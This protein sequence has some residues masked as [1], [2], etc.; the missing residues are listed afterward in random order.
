MS[1][2][3]LQNILK[4]YRS[5]A[6]STRGLGTKFERLI[7]NFLQNYPL[8]KNG[9]KHVWLW[10]EFPYRADFGGSDLG[11][12]IV[13][14]TYTGD[15]WAI[16]CKCYDEQ[17]FIDKPAVDSFL[18]TTSRTF[19]DSAN[20][21]CKFSFRLWIDTTI[22]G[23]NKNATESTANQDIQ[24]GRMGLDELFAADVDWDKLEAGLHG[25]AVLTNKKTVR[26]HQKNA[27]ENAHEYFKNNDRGKLIMACGT[28]KTF[29]SLKIAEKETEGKG[30]ILFLVP[31]IAL[32]GQT[33]REWSYDAEEKINPICICSDSEVSLIKQKKEDA[34]GFST[35]ELAMP[36]TTNAAAIRN[37][38]KK[39]QSVSPDGMLVCFSTYQSVDKVFKA[40]RMMEG[41]L[42]FDMMICDEAHRTTGVTLKDESESHFVCVHDKDFIKAKKRLYM[43]ATPRLYAESAQARARENDAVICSMDDPEIYGNEI[44]RIGFGEAVEKQLLSDYKVLVLTLSD[45]QVP[46]NLQTAIANKDSEIKMDDASKLIGC[47]NALSKRTLLD[48]QLLNES[49]PGP[50]HRAVAFCQNI[51]ISKQTSNAFNACEEAYFEVLSDQERK[52]IVKIEA[53]HVDGGMS[54]STRNLRLQWLKDTP[55]DSNECRILTNVR[56]LSEGVDVPSLDA[57]LFLSARNSQIDVVQSVGRVMRRAEGKKYGYIIIPVVIPSNMK[58]EDALNDNE[59]F[60]VVWSVL[61]ALRAHDDRFNATINKIELNRKKPDNIL[62]GGTYF[63]GDGDSENNNER[64]NE[65]A[66]Q[67][68]LQF[69]QLQSIIYAKMVQKV[70][71]K[72]YWEQWAADVAKIAERH[73]SQI[74]ELIVGNE[75]AGLAFAKFLDGL[76][77]NINPTVDTN[78]A[79][80]MLAQ[81]LITQPVFDALFANYS[82]A[83]H[84]PMSQ[85]LGKMVELLNENIDEKDIQLL[86][87]FYNSV[88]KRAEGIDN[89]EAKQKIIIELYDKFFKTA[90]P[91]VVEMLGIVY[92]PVEC[93][94]FILHSVEKV[95]N[96]EFGC[97]MSDE[98]VNVIDPFTGTGTFIT[99]LLQSGIIKKED[100]ERKYKNE[101][102]ANEIVLLAYYIASIN[103]ENVYHDIMQTE[104][105]TPFNGICLTDT[106][107]LG[108]QMYYN[109][110]LKKGGKIGEESF[111]PN[112]PENSA[113]IKKQLKQ[114]ITVIIGNPPYSVGQRSANDNAQNQSYQLLEKQIEEKYVKNSEA[115][116]NK[117]A[118]DSYIKAFRWASDRLKKGGGVIGFISNGAW[119]DSNGLDGFRKSLEQEFDSIYVFNLRGNQRTSGELSRKE[120]GK[121]FGSGSRTPIAITILVKKQ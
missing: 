121:I 62:V 90:F 78:T 70:G 120:G 103:I 97:S 9:L 119:L 77:R 86:E 31:S 68:S 45:S 89:A 54:A 58:P 15:Y 30:K 37:Q 114:P 7:Q 101:I 46:S 41:E 48:N 82:F 35:T 39:L 13:A 98:N 21:Q 67:L 59:R 104:T 66:V 108:E 69:E 64:N 38:Y 83:K 20:K 49:D 29:T 11:I 22:K 65:I 47:I 25:E 75:K 99:R 26:D 55:T 88:K 57:V 32:L 8:Y 10:N 110:S 76:R 17:A 74:K 71:D 91:R 93:V 116:L 87:R 72:R 61:N 56:C 113:R 117:A 112:F 79:V 94:D 42:D 105:Y 19:K 14:Q 84:N 107:Q 5:E 24:F 44:Y 50:M 111:A 6:A 18:A 1:A 53:D 60:A 34:D 102:F 80:E 36:A 12:D 63:G 16:Q 33:L 109:D 4:K 106:F 95:L 27:I 118:Y 96:K 100:L 51:N 85:S 23:F 92:T 73:I 3:Q 40:Q 81:H 2:I 43:T 115:N 52:E 28:G